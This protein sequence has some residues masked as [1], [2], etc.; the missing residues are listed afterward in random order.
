MRFVINCSLFLV[1]LLFFVSVSTPAL[2]HAVWP[3]DGLLVCGEHYAQETPIVVSDG[4]GGAI[5]AWNDLRDG[6]INEIYVQRV[7]G[8]GNLYWTSGGAR[9]SEEGECILLAMVSDGANG[10][11]ILYH[12]GGDI[13]AQRINGSSYRLWGHGGTIVSTLYTP[14]ELVAAPDGA[15][16]VVLAIGDVSGVFAQRV[17]SDGNVIWTPGDE[18]ACVQVSDPANI[19]AYDVCLAA[20]GAGGALVAFV[21]TD[22][23]TSEVRVYINRVFSS[24]SIWSPSGFQLAPSSSDQWHPAITGDGY[25]GAIIAFQQDFLSTST[26]Y[27]VVQK[28]DGSGISQWVFPGIIRQIGSYL[29][30]PDILSDG[31]GGAYVVWHGYTPS[32]NGIHAQRFDALGNGLWSELGVP[33][34]AYLE[35]QSNARLLDCGGGFIAVWRDSLVNEKLV[36]QKIDIAGGRVWPDAGAPILRGDTEFS[37]YGFAAD[38]GGGLVAAIADD[39]GA[40]RLDIYAQAINNFGSVAS[41]EPDITGVADVPGDQ[42]G[43]L[44]I[45]IAASDRDDNGQTLEQV[46]RYDV[47]QRVDDLVVLSGAKTPDSEERRFLETAPTAVNPDGT[48]ELIGSFDATQS[49]EYIY[50]VSTLADSTGAGIPYGCYIVS[51]HTTNPAVWYLSAPDSGYSVD[52]LAPDPPLSLAGEQS[53][54][55]EGMQL[56]WDP[57]TENDLWYYSVYRG[58]SETFTPGPGN[59][60]A[61]PTDE[62]WFDSGWGWEDGYWYK[63]S[64]VDENGNE[65]DFAVTGPDDATGVDPLPMPLTDF[66][67]Q[68]HPNPF[69]P[70]T[71]IAFGIKETALVSLRIY[72]ASG[73]LVRVLVNEVRDA[74][75]YQEVWDGRDVSGADSASGVYFYSLTAG[76]FKESRKMILLR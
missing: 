38:G 42:G 52:N 59:L 11:I 76:S 1:F 7:D 24:G 70:V 50:R 36:G 15:G 75:R 58:T 45:T 16:G 2:L 44:R 49:D 73:R 71:T 35:F 23:M 74:N 18:G 21:A 67:S 27:I 48:W 10:A 72:D 54:I 41:P 19:P 25:G 6:V 28:V 63:V 4:A 47:W 12:C 8:S 22:H 68:N 33:V 39:R 31:L 20:D 65:S 32:H 53:Q 64:A 9:L 3:P 56:T 29:E 57:N 30:R 60:V 40:S 34:S 61:T 13:H 51:A 55:P 62:E 37:D 5:I 26:K 43:A 69:N 17:D 46:M 66:L 14:D